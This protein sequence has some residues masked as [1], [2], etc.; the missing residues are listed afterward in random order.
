MTTRRHVLV[1]AAALMAGGLPAAGQAAAPV[2]FDPAA[3]AAAQAEGRPILVQISAP[4]CPICR[5]QKPI[6]ATFSADPRFKNLAIFTIDFDSQ[7][8]LV[9][10]F[11]AQ[12]QSTLIVYKG[13]AE[14][15]RSVGETQAEW[16]EQ[17]LEKAL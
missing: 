7:R 8:D 17:L 16:I 1:L 6:L 14:V 10:R 2:A 15:A 11:G 9:R 5:A 3:F 13:A 4:W 12:M